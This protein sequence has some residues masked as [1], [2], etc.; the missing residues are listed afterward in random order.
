M[1]LIRKFSNQP[2]G[3]SLPEK[4]LCALIETFSK[5]FWK[6]RAWNRVHKNFIFGDL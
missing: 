5:N 2:K 6:S 3:F 1:R 4:L